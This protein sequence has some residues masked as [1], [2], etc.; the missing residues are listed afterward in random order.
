[1]IRHGQT[2]A[3]AARLMAGS[4]DSPLT[5][6]GRAQAKDVH[7]A[8]R[9]LKTKPKHIIHSN[10]D[11]ARETATIIN[12]A[13]NLPMSEDADMA[14][15][16]AGDWEGVPYAQCDALFKGWVDPPNG[17]SCDT[18]FERIKTAKNR[19]LS[20]DEPVMIVSHGG[21]FRA[22]WKLYGI[23][24]EGV[25]NCKLYEFIP[26]TEANEQFPWDIWRYDVEDQ[27]SNFVKRVPVDLEKHPRSEI[28]D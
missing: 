6:L 21:V 10:L 7:A 12:E 19:A 5:D 20:K 27:D 11:R 23:H 26:K 15:M 9:S 18:F 1:M 8:V 2:E 17:E 16:H 14:E 13:L 24:N 4:L 28:R 25:Q 22:F 3:N